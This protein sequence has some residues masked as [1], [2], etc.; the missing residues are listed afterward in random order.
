MANKR[1]T[2]KSLAEDALADVKRVIRQAK[3]QGHDYA[4]Y[5]LMDMFDEMVP[6]MGS[7]AEYERDAIRFC[8]VI[9]R[10]EKEL[11]KLGY[12]ANSEDD[13]VLKISWKNG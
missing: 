1:K 3:K 2:V 5:E 12:E 4:G 8:N 9:E 10:M 13:I 7:S 11:R 6:G